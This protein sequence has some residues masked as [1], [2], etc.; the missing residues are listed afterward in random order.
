[1]TING[2]AAQ[3]YQQFDALVVG[4]GFSGLHQLYK[5]RKA[6]FS[7]KVFE[8]GSG[9]GGTW[10][11]NCY[12]GAR[13]DS[14]SF[15]YQLSLE[16]L[17]KDWNWTEKFPARQE[18]INY[19]DYIDKKL[20]LSRDISFNTRVTSA[21]FDTTTDRWS[22]GT[23]TGV[24][25]HPRFLILCTGFASKPLFPDLLGLDTFQGIVH[26]S[27]L[28][29]QGGIDLAGKRVGVIGTGASGV[30][31]IQETGPIAAYLTVFQRTP[32]LAL[33][34]CQR[35]LS[36][37]TQTKMKEQMYP[38]LFRR[39]HQTFAGFP[40]D[41]EH[42]SLFDISPEERYLV[43]DDKWTKGGFHYWLGAYEDTFTDERANAEVYAFWRK[44][45]LERVRDPEMQRKLA[46]E[47][48]PHPFGVKRPCLEQQYYEVYDQPNVALVDLQDNPIT[49]VT[50]NGVR[51]QDGIEHELDVLVL[52]TGFDAVTGSIAQININST[53]GTPIKDK[54]AKGLSTYLGLAVSGYPNMFFTYGPHGPTAFCNGPTCLEI[55]SDWI[56]DCL[57]YLRE[58]NHTRIDATPAAEQA[59]VQRVNDIF[60]N[61]LWDRAKSWYTGANV[62]GKRVESL[63]FTGGVPLYTSL[64]Q[65]CAENDYSGF[66]FT[67]SGTDGAYRKSS[68]SSTSKAR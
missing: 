12:P 27:A 4:A 58:H 9:L 57:I 55:Q 15:I 8:A 44:K 32:N 17:W 41:V 66:N 48:A 36:E 45:V 52:A 23:D 40:F 64:I 6:G 65:D 35:P 10:H 7:V 53:D 19:F 22:V 18:L 67:R 59:W 33:P 42:K 34:M 63:N 26:H 51:T 24:T 29:P 49:E 68:V 1:M 60:S 46:P 62:P 38:I 21:S 11:W 2:H 3:G 47:N 16:E 56:V 20:D 37:A 13:V 28:W 50:R 30:Q 31:I 39:C 61:A 54:W 5:L 25:A 14:E 43:F